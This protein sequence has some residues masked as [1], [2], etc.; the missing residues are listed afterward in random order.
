L[1]EQGKRKPHRYRFL[2]CSQSG[3][4]FWI[5][6]NGFKPLQILTQKLG[7]NQP[8]WTAIKGLYFS[9]INAHSSTSLRTIFALIFIFI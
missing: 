4:S 5:R 1:C 6:P 3:R 9:D 2:L 7:N 8:V